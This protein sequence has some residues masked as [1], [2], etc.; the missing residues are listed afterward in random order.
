M[1][2]EKQKKNRG[3]EIKRNSELKKTEKKNYEN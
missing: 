2:E 3:I 1:N